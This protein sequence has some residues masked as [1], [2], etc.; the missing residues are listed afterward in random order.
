MDQKSVRSEHSAKN[1]EKTPHSSSL[2]GP[3]LVEP[4]QPNLYSGT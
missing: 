1:I 4:S 2:M 3:S